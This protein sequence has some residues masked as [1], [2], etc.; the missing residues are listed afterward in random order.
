MDKCIYC[1][2]TNIEKGLSVGSGHTKT[3]LKYLVFAIPNV[4][5][6]YADLCKDCGSVRLYVKDTER[7]WA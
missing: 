6:F 4:E 3:G 1:N 2:S 7:N 5:W